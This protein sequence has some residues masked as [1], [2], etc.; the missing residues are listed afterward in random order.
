MDLRGLLPRGGR[1]TGRSPAGAGP[2]SEACWGLA[3]QTGGSNRPVGDGAAR[4]PMRP[5][6]EVA[7]T[8]EDTTQPA[9]IV[10]RDI[11]QSLLMDSSEGFTAF[12]ASFALIHGAVGRQLGGCCPG[13]QLMISC[14]INPLIISLINGKWH[15]KGNHS[16]AR[17]DKGKH[18]ILG[19]QFRVNFKLV[20]LI[21]L[22][23]ECWS[24]ILVSN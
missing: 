23:F 13:S 24:F 3:L 7:Q 16:E 22:R 17:Q 15:F 8:S 14:W 1:W 6:K 12:F 5:S 21:F 2:A 11:S 20:M 10:T 18:Y 19:I 9:R 4:A